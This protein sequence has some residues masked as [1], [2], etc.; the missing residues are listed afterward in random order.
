MGSHASPG[1]SPIEACMLHQ[2]LHFRCL[3][4]RDE[5]GQEHSETPP[6]SHQSGR[7]C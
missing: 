5:E 2:N 1:R 3:C 7:S 4:S 6:P